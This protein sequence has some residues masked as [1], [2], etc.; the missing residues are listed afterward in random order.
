MYF[1]KNYK[2]YSADF[3]SLYTNIPI[4]KA[5][6]IIMELVSNNNFQDI[7]SFAFY[8]FLKLILFNNYFFFKHNDSYTFFLQIKGI[9]MGS[10]CGP[11]I[12]NLYLSYLKSNIKCI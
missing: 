2:I 6:N 1:N 5:I 12:A 7:N 9:P 3:E 10:S 4:E 8:S 11:A